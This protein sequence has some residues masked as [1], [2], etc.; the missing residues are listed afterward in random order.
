MTDR[1][2]VSLQIC[3]SGFKLISIEL[4]ITSHSFTKNYTLV[5]NQTNECTIMRYSNSNQKA[6]TS[7]DKSSTS[8][9]RKT[10]NC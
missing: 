2:I 6:G 10:I 1:F 8:T 3:L 7:Q 5:S 9:G 4:S